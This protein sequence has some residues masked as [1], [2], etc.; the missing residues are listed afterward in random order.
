MSIRRKRDL[1]FI[2]FIVTIIPMEYLARK[3]NSWL[4][5]FFLSLVLFV[6]AF[7]GL[8]FYLRTSLAPLDG[9]IDIQG[10]KSPVKII[11]DQEGIPHIFAQNKIDLYRAYGFTVASERLFQMEIMR[12]MASGE[13]AEIIGEKGFLQSH[14]LPR[15][16]DPAGIEP[17]SLGSKPKRMS[18]TPW[19]LLI[20]YISKD[21][22][23]FLPI[24]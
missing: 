15:K 19:I 1:S 5:W 14:F 8:Y 20:S 3:K 18:S 11:R 16:T 21:I 13:L 12:R 24:I 22:K 10:L 23:Y 6:S 2:L 17:A 4:K 7:V 9:M